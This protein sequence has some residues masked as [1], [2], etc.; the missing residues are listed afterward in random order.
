MRKQWSQELYDKFSIPS[1]IVESKSY[2]DARKAGVARPFDHGDKVV[3]TSY[4]FAALKADEI[5]IVDWDLVV[6]DEAHRLRNVYKKDGSKRAK[7]LR[8]A[9]RS[10]RKILLTATPLQNSLMELYGL[11]SFLDEQHFGDESS[12]R[13]QYVAGP[14]A[15][16]GLVFLRKRLEPICTRTLRRQVQEAAL[17]RYTER[18]STTLHFEPSPDELRLYTAVSDYLQRRDTIAFGNKPNQLVTIVVRKILG[19]S[20]FA[21]TETLTKIIDRLKQMCPVDIET[22]SDYDVVDEETDEFED[23]ETLDAPTIIDPK[24]LEAEIA[25]LEEYRKLA[26][27]IGQNAKGIELVNALPRC[28]TKLQP[29]AENVKPLFL[30]N[31]CA[32]STISRVCSLR[33]VTKATSFYLMAKIATLKARLPI[34][35]G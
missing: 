22:V 31:L 26:L 15:K 17:I 23:D 21:I 35:T 1:T 24:K 29:R 7:R 20:T 10:F 19:S 5:T 8:D 16:N 14:G 25:E 33:R 18:C 2:N 4:E 13:S 27:A 9:T 11:V 12:F 6:F 32:P 30:L 34:K 28:L 3:I